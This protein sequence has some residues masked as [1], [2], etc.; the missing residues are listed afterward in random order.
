MFI[1]F[2]L[3]LLFPI[4]AKE[5]SQINIIKFSKK[6]INRIITLKNNYF[7]AHKKTAME[8]WGLITYRE[9][10]LLYDP[11]Y[12]NIFAKKRITIFISHELS[13]Q[14]VNLSILIQYTSSNP[15]IMLLY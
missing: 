7:Y 15:I 10:Y 14:W 13:H 4:L 6:F 8:N 12:E 3:K 11:K 2:K 9:S 1:V 5:V